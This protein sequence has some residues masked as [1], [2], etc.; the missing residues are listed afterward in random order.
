MTKP[1]S[2]ERYDEFWE[3]GYIVEKQLFNKD[4]MDLLLKIARGDKAMADNAHGPV[5][6]QGGISRLSLRNDLP[7][8]IYSACVRSR[9]VT[10]RVEQLLGDEI[11]H[12][13]HKMML[14]E[15][16]IGGAWEWHQD[17]GYWY[18]NNHCL[19]PDLA[20]AL[21]AVDRATKENG[22]LQVIR[23]SHKMGRVEHGRSG[24]QV[25]ADPQRVEAALKHPDMELVYCELEPGDL[26][27]FHSNVLHRS[28]QNRSENP[29]WS[30]I[31]CYNT[32]HN[33][34]FVNPAGH[35]NYEPMERW[36]DS[37][38]LEVGREQWEQMQAT[39]T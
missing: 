21:V 30:L 37:R 13:H 10:D 9:R 11:Y 23:G 26:L 39:T 1:L 25:G 14:K 18:K 33:D 38:I 20:S 19:Y 22:C 24:T 16:R 2:Q 32:R 28:D 29:R 12:W 5:D 6:A 34:P 4:E 27:I 8:D 31:C 15:P 35:P 17:Y 36:D 7:H 3:N